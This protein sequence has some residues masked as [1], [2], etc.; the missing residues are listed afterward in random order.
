M[1]LYSKH[2]ANVELWPSIKINR[3]PSYGVVTVYSII[4]NWMFCKSMANCHRWLTY[5]G[6]NLYRFHR[7]ICNNEVHIVAVIWPEVYVWVFCLMPFM[8]RQSVLTLYCRFAT[9]NR[10]VFRFKACCIFIFCTEPHLQTVN[11]MYCNAYF[12]PFVFSRLH[13]VVLCMCPIN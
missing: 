5:N 12:P 4:G 2:T 8:C 6:G 10:M 1:N 11:L 9:C 3:G 13:P 7:N